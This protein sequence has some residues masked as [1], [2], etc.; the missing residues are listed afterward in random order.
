MRLPWLGV[1]VCWFTVISYQFSVYTQHS[2]LKTKHYNGVEVC[3]FTV[4]SYQFSVYTQHSALKTKHYNIVLLCII[5]SQ[6]LLN[7]IALYR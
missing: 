5:L 3:W 4:I 7:H 6:Y 1:E 2:A